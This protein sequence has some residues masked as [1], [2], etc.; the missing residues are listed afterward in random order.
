MMA[1]AEEKTV[2]TLLWK[3]THINAKRK[4]QDFAR[5]RLK[6][7]ASFH[8]KR[9]RTEGVPGLTAGIGTVRSVI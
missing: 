9:P 3:R 2:T 8:G 7:H 1:G 5:C 6:A 4:Q